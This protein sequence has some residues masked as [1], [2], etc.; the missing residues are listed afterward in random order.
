MTILGRVLEKG[1]AQADLSA[2]S[3]GAAVPA[4]ARDHVA[5]LVELGVVGGSNGQLRPDAPVKRG[6]VAKMLFTLW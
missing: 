6:E 3:D 4:W 1:Y 2:F 5:T